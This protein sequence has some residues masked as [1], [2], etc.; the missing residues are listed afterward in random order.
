MNYTLKTEENTDVDYKLNNF[1]IVIKMWN[2]EG[3]FY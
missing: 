1:M 2:I 3:L